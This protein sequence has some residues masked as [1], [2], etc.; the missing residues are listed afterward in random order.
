MKTKKPAPL[1]TKPQTQ[2]AYNLERTEQLYGNK[3][4]ISLSSRVK[5]NS[6][7]YREMEKKR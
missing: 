1:K 3:S 6:E 5:H 7:F 2:E 4:L